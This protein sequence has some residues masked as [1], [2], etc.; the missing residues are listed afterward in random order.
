MRS[1]ESARASC[2]RVLFLSSFSVYGAPGDLSFEQRVALCHQYFNGK[3]IFSADAPLYA[4]HFEDVVNAVVHALHNDLAGIYNVCDNDKLPDTK[5]IDQFL[6]E[7]PDVDVSQAWERC[8]GVLAG[9]KNRIAERFPGC[10]SISILH[11]GAT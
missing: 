2:P 6:A 9:V 1:C 8:W 7:N 3:A 11:P 10:S 5:T 4:I